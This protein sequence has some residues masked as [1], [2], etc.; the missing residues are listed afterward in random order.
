[1]GVAAET[2]LG[3]CEQ[4]CS[5]SEEQGLN[6]LQLPQGFPMTWGTWTNVTNRAEKRDEQKRTTEEPPRR[7]C[8][9]E[10]PVMGDQ[11]L[12]PD[13]PGA[14]PPAPHPGQQSPH[15]WA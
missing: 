11:D 13:W 12:H 5:A 7:L 8:K 3:G 9:G 2:R 4:L 6:R 10:T 15:R 14:V 1:M